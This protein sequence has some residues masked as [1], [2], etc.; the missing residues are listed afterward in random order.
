[1]APLLTIFL[2]LPG[3]EHFLEFW[4]L[5]WLVCTQYLVKNVFVR[6]HLNLG[7]EG[8][9][10]IHRN[11]LVHMIRSDKQCGSKS[12]LVNWYESYY[13]IIDGCVVF[14]RF[15][16]FPDSSFG[17]GVLI[18]TCTCHPDYNQLKDH[19]NRDSLENVP[20]QLYPKC[21][22]PW[23]LTAPSSPKYLLWSPASSGRK[24]WGIHQPHQSDSVCNCCFK[25]S[26]KT[27][28]DLRVFMAA[29]KTWSP[30]LTQP[31]RLQS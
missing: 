30:C 1:M 12:A 5:A 8:E 9:Y 16:C 26:F 2:V 18:W 15:G 17:G 22:F 25:A 28:G 10:I 6:C 3:A 7:T 29:L 24:E 4:V 31:W 11:K 20:K 27:T 14:S 23:F 21:C 19:W 13:T